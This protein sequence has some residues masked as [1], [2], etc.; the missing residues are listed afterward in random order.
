MILVSDHGF[1]SDHLRPERIPLE[2]AGPAVQ[3]R[4]YGII[5]MKGPGIKKDERIYGA[6]LLD[7]CPTILNL[8]GLPVGLDMD[9]NVLVNAFEESPK[10]TATPSWDDIPGDDGSH[11][12]DMRIDPVEAREALIQLAALGYIEKPDENRET[13]IA[14]DGSGTHV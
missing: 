10:V 13:A 11:P 2:P 14:E 8:F 9:G 7:V 6:G 5:V 3:H 12:N 1:H 4:H